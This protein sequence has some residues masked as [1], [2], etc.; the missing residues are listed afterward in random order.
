MRSKRDFVVR[1]AA[2]EFGNAS[3]TWN[4]FEEFDAITRQRYPDA[5]EAERAPIRYHLRN[6][7]A[8]G[9]TYYNLNTYEAYV[10]WAQQPDRSQWYLSQM[11]PTDKTL[12]Q[13]EV[14]ETEKGLSLFYSTVAKPMRDALKEQ[15]ATVYGLQ[16][17][18]LLRTHLCARSYDWLMELLQLYPNH[19]VEF[20]AYSVKFGTLPN[21]NTVFWEVRLY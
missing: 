13:G 15:S 14:M 21:Y 5:W 8:G 4:T 18:S 3:P 9:A 11:A 17:T 10:R 16:A 6:R 1:Y 20:S 2:G 12:L 7:V 19:V